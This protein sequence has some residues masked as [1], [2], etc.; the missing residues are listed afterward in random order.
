MR[1]HVA[2]I[3][4]QVGPLIIGTTRATVVDHEVERRGTAQASSLRKVNFAIVC[5][6]LR[7]SHKAP[8]HRWHRVN[9][10]ATGAK[11]S[12]SGR[13]PEHR[14]SKLVEDSR[15]ND[16]HRVARLGESDTYCIS[17]SSTADDHIV[18]L[19]LD[20][21]N[22]L[23]GSQS[24]FNQSAAGDDLT[25]TVKDGVKE[26]IENGISKCQAGERKGSKE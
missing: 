18:E 17:T 2:V 15:F 10:L 7:L 8:V 26:W 21:K 16:G 9:Q 4:D 13:R 23:H 24:P 20:S 1:I 6:S 3:T 11:E 5:T 22:T 12:S 19:L 25:N 14:L